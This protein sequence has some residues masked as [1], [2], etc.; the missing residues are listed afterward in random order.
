MARDG[1]LHV[2]RSK[3]TRT[4]T[5]STQ[6]DV[7]GDDRD[8]Q[9]L[10]T[11]DRL[12]LYINSLN[13]G[14]DSF[15]SFTDDGKTWSKP[16]QIYL[17]GYILWKPI[18][19][20]GVHYAG[21]HRPGPISRRLSHLVTST[22]GVVWKRIST[23]SAGKG[24]SETSLHFS[25]DGQL[26]AFL[27]S[28]IYVGGFILESKPPYKTWQERR[29]G[30]HLSGHTVY[31]FDGIIYLTSRLLAYRP[32]VDSKLPRSAVA[33]RKLDQATMVYTYEG[34]NLKPY[35]RL[36]P[37]DGNHDSSY[38]EVVRDGNDML[39]VYHRASHVFAGQFR[40][41]DAADLFLARVPLKK[42]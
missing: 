18:T 35:C 9:L 22:D 42:P 23:I 26:T 40:A 28:Q 13:N 41:K 17:P 21:A 20:G 7:S 6:L 19:R 4:W 38:A 25:K 1:D 39:I 12:F 8:A 36:G 34:G 33:G 15:V 27:R 29:A 3:D 32:P 30:I 31:E 16:K 5:K 10:P 2:L 37:L 24:E 11:K 14:F